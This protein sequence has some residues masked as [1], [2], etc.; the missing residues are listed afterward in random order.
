MN[1][2][3]VRDRKVSA[4]TAFLIIGIMGCIATGAIVQTI[5]TIDFSYQFQAAAAGI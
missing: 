1:Y 2:R 5:R 3:D 4:A